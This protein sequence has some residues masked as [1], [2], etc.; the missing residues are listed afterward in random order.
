MHLKGVQFR[1]VFRV[2]GR[3]DNQINIQK[4][5]VGHITQIENAAGVAF[6]DI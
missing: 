3:E 1:V 2:Q 6:E 5:K 4:S